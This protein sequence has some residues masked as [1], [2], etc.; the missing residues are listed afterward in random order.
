MR[1]PTK[2][3]DRKLIGLHISGMATGCDDDEEAQRDGGD[4]GRKMYNE[5]GSSSPPLSCVEPA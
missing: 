5:L 1:R 4:A 2:D 3:R